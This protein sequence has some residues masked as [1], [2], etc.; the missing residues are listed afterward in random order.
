MLRLQQL[1][2]ARATLCRLRKIRE[3]SMSNDTNRGN[4]QGKIGRIRAES[5]PWWPEVKRAPKG[6]PNIVIVLMDDMG[7]SDPG[8]FG[9]E[10]GCFVA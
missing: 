6:A 3:K 1:C 8:C 7:Y 9:G 10:I 5:E 4:F 2:R